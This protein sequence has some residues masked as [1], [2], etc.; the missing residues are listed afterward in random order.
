MIAATHGPI[1]RTDL[2]WVLSRDNRWSSYD[3]E[4]GAIIVY[5]SMYGNTQKMAEVIARQLSVRGIRN[6]R[7]Y[8]SSK[9]HTSYIINDIFKYKGLIIGSCAYNNAIFPN[10]ETLL[11]TI[12]H[13]AVKNQYFGIFGNFLW[14]GGGVSNLKKFSEAMHCMGWE[15]VSEAVEEKGS[16]KPDKFQKCIDLANAMADKL[17][18]M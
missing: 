12:E 4:Q 3:K 5:G 6:I 2:N 8:D 7:V 1:W 10:I 11:S 13:M 17:L 16:L 9:T 14:N 15:T 18:E